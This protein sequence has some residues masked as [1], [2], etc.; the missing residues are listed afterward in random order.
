[1]GSLKSFLIPP[2]PT[3]I[4]EEIWSFSVLESG[5]EK[6]K[7]L[8]EL[9]PKSAH[10]RVLIA[11]EILQAK[12]R[13]QRQ[14]FAPKGGLWCVITLYDELFPEN[15][16]LLSILVGLALART[17]KDLGISEVYIKWINDLHYRGKKL[18]GVLIQKYLDWFLIG[19]GLN[20]NNPL[21]KGLPAVNLKTLLGK[22]LPLCKILEILLFWLNYYYKLLW[23]YEK[24]S[25]EVINFKNPLIYDL[26]IYSDTLGKCIF[27]N[28]NIDRLEEGIFGK[29]I[30]FTEKGAL[31]IHTDSGFI[32]VASGEILYL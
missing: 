24:E 23:E 12:G 22:E 28:Y 27:Y 15:Y 7:E 13:F 20:V 2:I 21:P 4:G 9:F 25:L 29:A 11:G 31:I 32:E 18:A 1:M 5:F 3:Y 14:W 10:G 17:V 8:I 16:G 6:A 19:I 30:D 26:K